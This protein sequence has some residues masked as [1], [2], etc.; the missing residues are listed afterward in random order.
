MTAAQHQDEGYVGP[1]ELLVTPDGDGEPVAVRVTLRG[2]FQPIDGRYHWYGRVAQDDH[3]DDAVTSGA[4]VTIRTPQ[5]SA[6]GKLSDRDP[7]GRFRISGTGTPPFK[8]DQ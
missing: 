6:E 1:A 3:L 4:A 5:G 7:W 2:V 8:V